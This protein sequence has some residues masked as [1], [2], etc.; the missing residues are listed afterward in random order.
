M[1]DSENRVVLGF[2]WIW[3]CNGITGPY[4]SA[5]ICA[6]LIIIPFVLSR[7]RLIYYTHNTKTRSRDTSWEDWSRRP[8]ATS[9]TSSARAA[10]PHLP[11][12]VML[13]L[14]WPAITART[15][16][17]SRREAS[18]SWP[19]GPLLRLRT[20]EIRGASRGDLYLRLIF[21]AVCGW[22]VGILFDVR[23]LNSLIG[24]ALLAHSIYI[25]SLINAHYK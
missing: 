8:T 23:G 15:S 24:D 6:Q 16:W 20:E 4:K 3:T 10:A 17:A 12:S 11:S 19:T 14:W 13:R 9:W 5:P 2:W 7:C 22:R 18:A 25:N 1:G 21:F